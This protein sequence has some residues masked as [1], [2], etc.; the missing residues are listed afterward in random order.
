MLRKSS[1]WELGFVHYIVKF[2]ISR[3]VISRFEFTSY[4]ITISLSLKFYA[5]MTNV[6]VYLGKFFHVISSIH[7]WFDLTP[8][9]LICYCCIINLG[10]IL[11][12]TKVNSFCEW[13]LLLNLEK[14]I[15]FKISA[16]VEC[17]RTTTEMTM[18]ITITAT[19]M[20]IVTKMMTQWQ[21][22]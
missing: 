2:T 21:Q 14:K 1:K 10:S 11:S 15:T 20:T 18:R 13:L 16:V 22:Q 8:C 7:Y 4:L 6:A 19:L 9:Q 17:C 5:C 3:F 12:I